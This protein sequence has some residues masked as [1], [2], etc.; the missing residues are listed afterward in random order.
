MDIKKTKSKDTSSKGIYGSPKKGGA[1]GKGTWGKGGADD[2]IEAHV[3]SKDP[4]YDS[5]EEV[6]LDG[7][8][9]S[10]KKKV[11]FRK[12]DGSSPIQAIL[13]EYFTS[14]DV[15]E[16]SSRLRELTAISMN[17]FVEKSVYAA[18]EHQPYER[19]L[20]SKLLSNLY[21]KSLTSRNISDGF[22]TALDNLEE[23]ILDIPQAPDMLAKFFARAILDEIIPPSFLRSVWAENTATQNTVA[24]ATGLVNNNHRSKRLEHIWGPGDLES[25]KRLKREASTLVSEFIVNEDKVEADRSL[26]SMSAPHFHFQVVRQAL[27]MAIGA[28]NAKDREAIL[29]LLGFLFETGLLCT[30]DMEQGFSLCGKSLDDTKLDIPSAPATFSSMVKVGQDSKW[31]SVDFEL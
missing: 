11:V 7:I 30:S 20:T 9:N 21:G 13:E 12:L 4:N 26:R 6:E 23:N 28:S 31:L 3:D 2:L 29:R 25:V 17:D 18:M 8:N 14:G 19:E 27:Q 5:D 10:K 22:Q 15:E 16:A 1:G 24:I